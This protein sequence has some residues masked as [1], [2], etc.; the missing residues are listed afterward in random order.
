V[1]N[2]IDGHMMVTT[3]FNCHWMVD[4]DF[5]HYQW[6]GPIFDRHLGTIKWRYKYFLTIQG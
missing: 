4:Y 3:K 2:E 6:I 1:A 5:G